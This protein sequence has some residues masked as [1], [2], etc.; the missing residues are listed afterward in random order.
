[1][2]MEY[3]PVERRRVNVL[4]DADVVEAAREL[5]LNISRVTNRALA[6]EVKAERDR[7]WVEEHR[8]AMDAWNTWFEE[9]GMPFE[10]LR[11]F[12]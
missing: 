7:R 8:P 5:Q 12:P 9:N 4:L 3:A 1:M 6:M 10:E 11:V 2:R